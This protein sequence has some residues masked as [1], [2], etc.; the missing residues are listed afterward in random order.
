M[1]KYSK[2]WRDLNPLPAKREKIKLSFWARLL[3]KINWA[4]NWGKRGWFKPN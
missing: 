4:G 3:L 2:S 1:N